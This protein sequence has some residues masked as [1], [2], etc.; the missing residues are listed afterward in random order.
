MHA[1]THSLNH[2]HGHL[3]LSSFVC[4]FITDVQELL[5]QYTDNSCDTFTGCLAYVVPKADYA[6]PGREVVVL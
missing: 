5:S 3:L 1:L 6:L 4:L 2:L